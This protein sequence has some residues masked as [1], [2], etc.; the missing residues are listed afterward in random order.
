M[1]I[2]S[3][4]FEVREVKERIEKWLSD[5]EYNLW[6][7]PDKNANFSYKISRDGDHPLVVF[8]PK[9][10]TDSIQVACDIRLREEERK[11]LHGISEME[12]KF[13]LF[14]FKMVLL[15]TGCR[16]QFMPSSKSWDTLK[17]WKSIFYDGLSKDRFFETIESVLRAAG[18]VKLALEWKFDVT[19]YVS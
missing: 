6:K 18:S 15:S 3:E 4:M 8:Q 14:D 7:C 11:K 10:K 5:E 2:I 9:K 17:I 13:M 19:P 1:E 12:K 16:W